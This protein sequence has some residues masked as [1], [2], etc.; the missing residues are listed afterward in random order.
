MATYLKRL[1]LFTVLF[2]IPRS[3]SAQTGP[4]VQLASGSLRGVRG[5]GTDA[6][7]GIPFAAPPVGELRWAGSAPVK[8]WQGVFEATHSAASCAQLPNGDGPGS[9]SEDCLYLDVYRPGAAA[10]SA[11]LPVM[12]FFHGGGNIFGTPAIYD[13]QRMAE[14]TH[15]VVVMPAYRLGVFGLLA[16]PEL[17]PNSGTYLLQDQ[18]AALRWV[19]TNIA[20]FGGNARDVTLSGESSGAMDV[21]GLLASPAADGL[22]RQAILQCGFCLSGPS[23]K[24]AQHKSEDTARKAGCGGQ[25]A[26]ACMKK[27]SVPELLAAGGV[28]LEALSGPAY[29]GSYLPQDA[30]SAVRHGRINKVPVL[31][32]FNEDE[33]WPFQHGLYP[34]SAEKYEQLLKERYP[35][36]AADL[37]RLYPVASY[38]HL[39]YSIGAITGDSFMICP[40]LRDARALAAWTQVSVYEFADRSAPPFKSLGPSLPRPPGYQPGAFH[41]AEL[42]YLYNYQSAEGPLSFEQRQLGDRMIQLWVAFNRETGAW[43]RFNGDRPT[44]VRLA[45]ADAASGSSTAV[46][47]EHHCGFW[48]SLAAGAAEVR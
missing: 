42:Q 22:F 46:E 37:N 12:V 11:K 29:G 39:E 14:I 35:K 19:Q 4:V 15:A 44:I 17:G 2:P 47:E 27:K 34:L 20:A 13:G 30:A 38:P 23:L 32:G 31:L 7:L 45:G 6:F 10:P 25:D 21:C 26:L 33:M 8:P 28:S 48:D 3:A 5:A 43:P 24:D 41:T 36:R 40:I 1:L 18:I 16:L 9:S